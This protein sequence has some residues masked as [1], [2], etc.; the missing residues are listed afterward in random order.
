MLVNL[1]GEV[2]AVAIAT[3]QCGNL[4]NGS[5]PRCYIHI[6]SLCGDCGTDQ[7]GFRSSLR[8][9]LDSVKFQ[10]QWVFEQPCLK[11]QL[12]LISRD[13]MRMIDK[14][15]FAH[16]RSYGYFGSVAKI[17]HTWRAHGVKLSKVWEA[18]V[19]DAWEHKASCN[20]PPLAVAGRWGSIDGTTAA[21]LRGMCS[22]ELSVGV[23]QCSS[24][25]LRQMNITRH[26]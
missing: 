16:G 24:T 11:H 7:T 4:R 23:F 17:V 18:I 2:Q 21:I 12:H 19:P 26:T 22:V 14:V 5:V 15:L 25:K 10:N 6:W 9:T 1:A 20:V 8:T 3:T 13:M